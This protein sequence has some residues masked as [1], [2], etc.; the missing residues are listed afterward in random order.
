MTEEINKYLNQPIT[1]DTGRWP[2]GSWSKRCV[3]NDND[4]NEDEEKK[5]FFLPGTLHFWTSFVEYLPR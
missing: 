2:E 5:V 1:M 4:N 3:C